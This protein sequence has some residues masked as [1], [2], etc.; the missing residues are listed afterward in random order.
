VKESPLEPEPDEALVNL[1]CWSTVML[2]FVYEPGDTTV[3][4]RLNA[5]PVYV[6]PVP[7]VVVA[8]HVGTPETSASVCPFVPADVVARRVVP[9]PKS[10]VLAWRLAHPVPPLAMARIPVM[11]DARSMAA[12]A[13][14]PAVALRKP[15]TFPKVKEFEATRLEVEAR[16]DTVSAVVEASGMVEATVVEV[17][18]K[19]GAVMVPYVMKLFLKSAFPRTSRMLPVVEVAL[20]PTRVT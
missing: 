3:S 16:F 4:A 5:E 20:V 15:E 13:T 14:T 1:P 6:S 9:F 12:E 11:S 10:T 19:V 18:M 17:A 8:T 2:A 7:A